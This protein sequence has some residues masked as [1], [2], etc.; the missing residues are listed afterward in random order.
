MKYAAY[1]SYRPSGVQSPTQVPSHWTIKGARHVCRLAYGESLAAETRE[2]GAVAVYGSNGPVG[3]HDIANTRAPVIVVGRK[4]SFGKLNYSDRPV[5]A[6]DTT[7]FIDDRCTTERLDWLAYALV[8]LELDKA[9]KDSAVPGL[10]REDAYEHRMPV[11]PPDEQNAIARFLDAK[12]AQIDTLLAKKRQLIDKLK[13]KRSARIARTVTRGLPPEA[14]KAAGL[15]P[16]PAMKDSGVSWLRRLPSHWDYKPTKHVARIGN[17]STP[18]RDNTDYW[19]DGH[20][21]WLNSSVVNQDVVTGAEELVTASALRECHLPVIEPPAVL[22]GITGQGRTRG[23]A[24]TLAIK[25]TINQHI[26]YVKP[27][28][29]LMDVHFMRRVFD[30]AYPFLRSESDG[31]GSTKG[32]ITCDQIANLVLPVPPLAEQRAIADYLG[33]AGAETD[34]LTTGVEAAIARLTE[35]RQALITSAVTGKIDVRAWQADK[36]PA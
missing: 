6:I 30:Y 18:A 31:G 12:S 22:I 1:T 34:A 4:G 11:P 2:E 13:E 3:S 32:A 14:A 28:A 17:G 29:H 7:Y 23:M 5:F 33:H 26:A 16:N 20:F 24:T 27:R 25:A 10:S 15:E 21:P 36:E 8:P 19:E 9:S 35:Y